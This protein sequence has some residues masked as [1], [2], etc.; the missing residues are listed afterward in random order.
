MCLSC[1]VGVLLPQGRMDQDATWYG[2]RP[3]PGR[4][5]VTWERSSATEMGTAAPCHCAANVYCG[6]TAWWIRIPLGT[7]V[8]LGPGNIVLDGDP[9]PPQK[10][11]QHPSFS[12]HVSCGHTFAY[13][14]N[15]WALVEYRPS[16]SDQVVKQP[17]YLTWANYCVGWLV[18][19][20]EFNDPFQHK[21]GYIRDELTACDKWL[22]PQTVP[23]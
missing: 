19:W 23:K 21:Y 16:L 12:I 17:F 15:W 7:E 5:C 22:A 18:G 9:D 14:S 11:A 2:G 6:Q 4:H 13:L 1:N 10:L 20:M 3:Q 8:D